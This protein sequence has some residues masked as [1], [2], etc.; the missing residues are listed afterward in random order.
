MQ[1]VPT[2]EYPHLGKG[3][4]VGKV[5]DVFFH[6]RIAT[7]QQGHSH[8]IPQLVCNLIQLPMRNKI[9]LKAG[10]RKYLPFARY[11]ST[12]E[13]RASHVLLHSQG[14]DYLVIMLPKILLPTA[15]CN[16]VYTSGS[17]LGCTVDF[18]SDRALGCVMCN[19]RVIVSVPVNVIAFSGNIPCQKIIWGRI[20]IFHWIQ[21]QLN[22][23]LNTCQ[24]IW[25]HPSASHQHVE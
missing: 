14:S 13:R 19:A 2:A 25:V 18:S 21:Q 9:R 11:C 12:G 10:K 22:A 24:Q 1:K 15:L 23:F 7:T 5:W 8:R 6:R 20:L 3:S 4:D 17:N 16:A